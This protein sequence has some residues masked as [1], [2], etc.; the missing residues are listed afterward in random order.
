MAPTPNTTAPVN[1]Q[2]H[3][4]DQTHLEKQHRNPVFQSVST[5]NVVLDR[6][7]VIRAATPSYLAVTCRDEEEL[8]GVGLFEAFPENPETS[9]LRPVES[10]T[11]SLQR[12]LRR[13]CSDR[14]A[15]LRYDIPDPE[16]PHGTY[17]R[18]LWI[19]VSNPIRRG[20]RT[21]GVSVLVQD[22]TLLDEDL[23][24]ALRHYQGLLEEGDLRMSAAR[25]RLD[26]LGAFVA[27]TESHAALGQEVQELKEAL[28]SRPAIEQAKG[29]IMAD[30]RCGADE[31]FAI[32]KKLS[33][34]SNVRVA[35]V[36]TALVYQVQS[37]QD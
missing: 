19:V 20:D 2:R 12:V 34:D 5:P 7:L 8:L 3:R 1:G 33:M 36:A 10:L 23:L 32:L 30:R 25:R 6:E 15:P 9:A 13:S 22:V 21:L 24:S 28:S 11:G 17:L 4:S 14:L 26:V 27:T 35:D 16:S 37:P 29:I 31:A 18:K